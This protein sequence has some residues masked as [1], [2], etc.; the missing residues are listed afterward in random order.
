MSCC[1][2]VKYKINCSTCDEKTNMANIPKIGAGSSKKAKG[3][4]ATLKK[5]P[6]KNSAVLFT[7]N[8]YTKSLKRAAK[9]EQEKRLK[10]KDVNNTKTET[11]K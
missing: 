11:S 9:L 10:A 7:L 4:K 8:P 5:N 6:L 3:R 2:L 1:D